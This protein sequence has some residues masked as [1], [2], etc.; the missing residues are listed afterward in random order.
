AG[1]LANDA[2]FAAG[3]THPDHLDR[4]LALRQD[5]IAGRRRRG[6]AGHAFHA[7]IDFECQTGHDLIARTQINIDRVVARD[8]DD[9]AICLTHEWLIDVNAIAGELALDGFELL[10]EFAA[11]L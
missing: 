3:S 5:R 7:I 1:L 9:L 10:G 11:L 8:T 2:G 4:G 6:G